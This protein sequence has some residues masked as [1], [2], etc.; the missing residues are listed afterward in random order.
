MK[1]FLGEYASI[2]G[3]DL[4]HLACNRRCTE[5]QRQSSHDGSYATFSKRIVYP[6][7]SSANGA[8][9]RS[10]RIMCEAKRHATVWDRNMQPSRGGLRIPRSSHSIV[11]CLDGYD[12]PPQRV[13]NQHLWDDEK[14]SQRL[15]Q[16]R[17]ARHRLARGRSSDS[18]PYRLLSAFS[19]CAPDYREDNGS[20]LR[21]EQRLRSQ[22]S[23]AAH[24]GRTVPELFSMRKRTGVPCSPRIGN[25]KLSH[26][27]RPLVYNTSKSCQSLWTHFNR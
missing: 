22:R 7:R 4:Q 25:T 9:P 11:V 10:A 8:R 27:E 20:I 18:P 3:N 5:K 15:P 17:K 1:R 26:L 21:K 24:S 12:V 14:N 6:G 19:S 13:C 16:S 23:L 2:L